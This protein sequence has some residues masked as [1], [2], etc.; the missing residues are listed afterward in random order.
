MF[1]DAVSPSHFSIPAS[2]SFFNPSKRH[3][4]MRDN[5]RIPSPQSRVF[6]PLFRHSCAIP[7]MRK[8]R[9]MRILPFRFVSFPC[10]RVCDNC[11]C[12]TVSSHLIPSH[13]I[14]SHLFLM[15]YICLSSPTSRYYKYLGQ[16]FSPIFRM[17]CPSHT[18]T[19]LFF[20]ISFSGNAYQWTSRE[21][22]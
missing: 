3:K 18:Q 10:V 13:L 22:V 4:S 1:P 9:A 19:R 2:S 6:E 7:S 17:L 20:G 15:P 8:K 11:A 5:Q 16:R 12:V 14:S 21:R